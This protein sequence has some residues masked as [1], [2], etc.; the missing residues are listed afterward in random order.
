MQQLLNLGKWAGKKNPKLKLNRA[1]R[2]RNYAVADVHEWL[3]KS[4]GKT[5]QLTV[6]EIAKKEGIS[7]F[8]VFGWIAGSKKREE[9]PVFSKASK[10]ARYRRQQERKYEWLGKRGRTIDGDFLGWLN[11]KP[12]GC[13]GGGKVVQSV[14][15]RISPI[16]D[17]S[18]LIMAKYQSGVGVKQL[19][20]EFMAGPSTITTMLRDG[21][22]NT[23][24][25]GN[26][27]NSGACLRANLI[28]WRKGRESRD[29][30]VLV[31][32]KIASRIWSGLKNQGIKKV[33][34]FRF[35]GCTQDQL[36]KHLESLFQAGMN[37]SNYGKWH[38]DHIKPVAL[39]DLTDEAQR[40]ECFNWKNLQ[41][42]W[43]KD[44]IKKGKK[45]AEVAA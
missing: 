35:V 33:G 28:K 21:G 30:G 24:A 39:F 16:Y 2:T 13:G 9:I 7:L 43:A 40:K 14:G 1:A 22:I 31:R 6:F 34:L 23:T 42:L 10:S 12:V 11:S 20:K 8:T 32:H 19:G 44:N 27:K 41:P 5:F 36:V 25:R 37:W 18:I 26:K 3:E 45:Y 4:S 17:K 15:E 38:V 29:P